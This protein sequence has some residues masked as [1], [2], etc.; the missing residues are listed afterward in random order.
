MG[1]APKSGLIGWA[2]WARVMRFQARQMR[3]T[4]R[5]AV[6]KL[7]TTALLL[8]VVAAP[9]AAQMPGSN[10]NQLHLNMFGDGMHFKTEEEVKAEKDKERAYKAG[11][12]KIPD[13]KA[14]SDPWGNVRTTPPTA[15]AQRPAP[16]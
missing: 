13:Q 11:M 10:D 8:A 7:L 6:K 14:K 9:A 15:T 4:W 16:K 3:T 12:S 2:A 5:G 1:G